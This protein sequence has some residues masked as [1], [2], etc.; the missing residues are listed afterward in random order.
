MRRKEEREED[1]LNRC[2]EEIIVKTFPKTRQDFDMLYDQV[3]KW[4]TKEVSLS[5]SSQY[6]MD[7]I[8]YTFDFSWRELTDIIQG[9]QR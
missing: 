8:Q 6:S 4:K 9:D 3:Q 2:K 7:Q 5:L 1:Y